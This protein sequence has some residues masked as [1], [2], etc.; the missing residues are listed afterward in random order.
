MVYF[1]QL[2]HSPP[3]PVRPPK[4]AKLKTEGFVN[5]CELNGLR[6]SELNGLRTS[7]LNGLRTS[8]LNSLRTIEP[9]KQSEA[10]GSN[11][12]CQLINRNGD[13]PCDNGT[14]VATICD[15]GKASNLKKV[16]NLSIS[17]DFQESG[18]KLRS[19]SKISRERRFRISESS[20]IHYCWIIV[21]C[22][23]MSNDV[24]CLLILLSFCQERL[25]VYQ[26]LSC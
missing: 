11:N 2:S 3:P 22:I 7:E 12:R 15:I 26:G 13:T 9:T 16:D 23:L 1:R 4:P 10:Q 25:V 19:G 6:T 24:C 5:H 17:S 14:A 18:D 20:F 21:E 8:E